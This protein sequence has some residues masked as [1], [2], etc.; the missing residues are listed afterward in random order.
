MRTV[1]LSWNPAASGE[2]ATSYIVEVGS[3][4]GAANLLVHPTGN[5]GTVLV[6]N[7]VANGTYFIRV[8]AVTAL[9][10]SA[11]SN[12]AVA[13]VTGT[14]GP[15][16]APTPTPSAAPGAPENFRATANGGTVTMTWSASPAGGTPLFY[17]IE[18]GTGPGLTNLV[19]FSTGNP[20]LSFLATAPAGTYFVRVRAGNALG[21]SGPS[22]EA[23][24]VV[25]Q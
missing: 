22:N 14:P 18:A 1:T 20:G 7:N 25:G 6:A 4:S 16:P 13:V 9:G 21:V 19:S 2:P 10:L 24:L 17:V 8:R 5:A 23:I 3:A 15:P 11:A 12:E